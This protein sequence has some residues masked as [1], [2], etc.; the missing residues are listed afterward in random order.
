MIERDL[1]IPLDGEH[2]R[3]NNDTTL[4]PINRQ[5]TP[6]LTNTLDQQKNIDGSIIYDSD[7]NSS[8]T[9]S[10]SDS[11]AEWD[12]RHNYKTNGKI[13]SS[14]NLGP[15]ENALPKSQASS[16]DMTVFFEM[17]M[18][19]GLIIQD[20]LY[21]TVDKRY[22]FKQQNSAAVEKIDDS[23]PTTLNELLMNT[24][25]NSMH[26]DSLEQKGE[27]FIKKFPSM[28]NVNLAELGQPTERMI[29]DLTLSLKNDVVDA[30]TE[31]VISESSSSYTKEKQTHFINRFLQ[32]CLW[33]RVKVKKRFSL[34]VVNICKYPI[35][36]ARKWDE[37]ILA[38]AEELPCGKVSLTEGLS[39]NDEMR[40]IYQIYGM[41]MQIRRREGRRKKYNEGRKPSAVLPSVP[42][43][44]DRQ[45]EFMAI[46]RK[47]LSA[48][49]IRS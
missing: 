45:A 21:S 14:S 35:S 12:F 11:N 6:R 25:E 33:E 29:L 48:F 20:S 17:D 9:R 46:H 41:Y 40:F 22:F 38:V 2:L 7:D 19:S 13:N 16:A 27:S 1:L 26:S 36:P 31:M 28:K 15:L 32:G 47:I 8:H 24:R 30:F 44:S 23:T 5:I 34:E 49:R 3:W 10:H 4:A 39:K 43:T 18:K 37:F 42:N